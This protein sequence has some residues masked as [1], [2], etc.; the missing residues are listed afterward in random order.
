MRVGIPYKVVG[1]VRFYERKEIKDF[2]AYLRVI[3]NPNDEVSMRRIINTPKRGIGDRA[4]DQLDLYSQANN[5]TFWQSL[6][7]V[8]KNSEL[9][10]RSSVSLIDFVKLIQSLQT[11]V[12]A[13]TRPS[14]IAQAVLEQSG[15]LTEL[16]QSKDPQDEVRVENLEEL[17]AVA[18]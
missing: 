9:A 16:S 7:E 3:V 4:L 2:L 12:E 1:G 6:C 18:T 5:L 14:V 11:L 15:L 13:K 10:Q 17:I 8:E